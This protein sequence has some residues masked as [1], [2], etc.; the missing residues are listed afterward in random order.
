MPATLIDGKSL[1]AAVRASLKGRIDALAA[2][3]T[4]AGL[5]AVLAGEDAASRV[6]VR[7]K[8]R[9]C[10]E[11]GLRS[12]VHELRG[13]VS[14]RELLERIAR[15]NADRAVHGI[16]VQLPLPRH[17]DADRILPSISPAKDVD[18]FHAA[19]LG[20]LVQGRPGFVPGTPAGV[21]RMLEHAGVALAGRHA[22]VVGRSTIVGKPLALL[23]LQKD[24]TVT[25][26]HSKTADLAA[27]TRG[28]DVLV[29]AVGRAKLITAPMVKPGAC[30]I[31]VGINR[32]ADGK[33][34]GDVDFAAVKEVAG[35]ISPVP[36][37]VGPMTVA[38]LIVNTVRSAELSL[39]QSP[40]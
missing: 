31:D 39:E 28:A 21:M 7:N 2:R 14:E 19:N 18:G 32:M 12:E 1:A 22:V 5:A 29:A 17:L 10:E 3:G 24:A 6:Y 36:G 23:L 37:G 8:A 35:S 25:I 4:R 16:V 13:D 15:L 33:L 20:A 27:A 11:T 9:A 38:M 40:A 30:V 34:C 26:C